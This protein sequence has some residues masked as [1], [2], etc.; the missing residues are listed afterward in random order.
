MKIQ[1]RGLNKMIFNRLFKAKHLD[2]DPKVRLQSIAKL[3]L[4]NP[5]DKQALHELAFNDSNVDVSVAALDKLNSFPLWLKASETSEIARLKK[6]ANDRVLQ[7]VNDS[8]SSL[9]SEEEFDM[10]VIESNNH[11]L[12]EQILFNNTRLQKNDVLPLAVL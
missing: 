7:E 11:G 5:S 1:L 4:D 2:S 12:L 10:F 6:L 3:S 8:S 9:L